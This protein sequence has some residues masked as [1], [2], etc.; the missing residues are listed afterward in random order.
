MRSPSIYLYTVVWPEELDDTRILVC[1]LDARGGL[2]Y[3]TLYQPDTW[4]SRAVG[5]MDVDAWRGKDVLLA[6][7]Y[8]H[9]T[10]LI[11]K[12]DGR[13]NPVAN[14][15]KVAQACAGLI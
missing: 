1:K 4:G 12:E 6:N 15:I 9:F 13:L 5:G 11:S 7:Q 14:L 10:L 3:F 8:G 2:E